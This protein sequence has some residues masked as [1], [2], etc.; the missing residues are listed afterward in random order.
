MSRA[1]SKPGPG[2]PENIIAF[3]G[4][5]YRMTMDREGESRVTLEVPLT[6]L[7]EVMRL[8]Q[9]KGKLLTIYVKREET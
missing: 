5:L 3:Q 6:A 9:W 1:A 2:K 7:T 4:A 8:S